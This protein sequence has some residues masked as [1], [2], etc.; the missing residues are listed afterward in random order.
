MANPQQTR[1]ELPSQPSSSPGDIR[2]LTGADHDAWLGLWRGYQAFYEVDIAEATSRVTWARL[3]DPQEPVH[4]ALALV[5][6]EPAGLVHWIIHR[7]T[8]TEGDYCYLQDLFVAKAQRGQ[9]LGRRLILHVYTEAAAHGCSRVHW[10]THETN[11][12]AM[13]LYARLAL[14]PGFVQW[15]KLLP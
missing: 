8:W 15:R 10:L 3:L 12:D 11:H 7:S 2:P 1:S 9:G 6:N 5:A 14:R 13:R 4:G